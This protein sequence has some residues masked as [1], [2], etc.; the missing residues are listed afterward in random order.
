MLGGLYSVQIVFI[1]LV[2]NLLQLI[3]INTSKVGEFGR[4]WETRGEDRQN[5]ERGAKTDKT[6]KWGAIKND[7]NHANDTTSCCV[8]SWGHPSDLGLLAIHFGLVNQFLKQGKTVRQQ[9]IH[10]TLT[11]CC[12]LLCDFQSF[13]K[14]AMVLPMFSAN[15]FWDAKNLCTVVSIAAYM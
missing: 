5:W 14:S 12:A 9:R 6:R 2:R 11:F 15:H 10:G 13:S 8:V 7:A 1:V 4:N 3:T